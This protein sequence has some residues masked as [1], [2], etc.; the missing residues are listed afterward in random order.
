MKIYRLYQVTGASYD[1]IEIDNIIPEIDESTIGYFSTREKAEQHPQY[2]AYIQEQ[3]YFESLTDE[4][5][6]KYNEEHE[7]DYLDKPY[8]VAIEEI[9]VID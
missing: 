5:K 7:F 3:K 1:R 9:D 2:Q 6:N 8:Y 4:E